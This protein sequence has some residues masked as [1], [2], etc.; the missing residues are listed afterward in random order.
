MKA[1][2]I[3]IALV[4]V[5]GHASAATW[6]V[7][8]SGGGD[9]L[10]IQEA[11][12]FASDGDL[13]LVR[14]G[15]YAQAINYRGKQLAVESTNGPAQ[16][17]IDGLRGT[18]VRVVSGEPTGTVLRGFTVTNGEIGVSVTD[19]HLGLFENIIIANAEAG[20]CLNRSQ[21]VIED[22][23][24]E[25][26]GLIYLT[27]GGLDAIDSD[28]TSRANLFERN[29]ALWGGGIYLERST[30]ISEADV[31]L[32]NV[33]FPVDEF[34]AGGGAIAG[35]SSTLTLSRSQFSHNS[36]DG[37]FVSIGGGVYLSDA[38]SQFIDCIFDRNQAGLGGG[39]HAARSVVSIDKCRF[40]GNLAIGGGGIEFSEIE[41]TTI[42]NSVFANN[43]AVSQGVPGWGGAM[44]FFVS[45][46][47]DMFVANCTLV[48][49]FGEGAAV[50]N[51]SSSQVKVSN[52]ICRNDT[53]MSEFS[54]NVSVTYSN[55]RGGY[56]GTANFDAD[57]LFL[58][59]GDDFHLQFGSP[60]IGAGTLTAPGVPTDDFDGQ[61][62]DANNAI[63]VGADEFGPALYH[64]LD[65]DLLTVRMLDEPST[66]VLLGLSF[67]TLDPPVP[68]PFGDWFLA[69][70]LW[71]LSV[72]STNPQGVLELS[73]NVTGIDA[74][75]FLQ[76]F[77]GDVLT[78]LEFVAL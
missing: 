21:V 8:Q 53:P 63:D 17:V 45:A 62:R 76:S 27:G 74:E 19:S 72:G 67:S 71:F 47:V 61:R 68:T 55:V 51:A 23:I 32:G 13:I 37:A 44:N 30:L 29:T 50:R 48:N 15:T 54:G 26:N 25:A 3:S 18:A 41:G 46:T 24:F 10:G 40:L 9:F 20:A 4:L 33:V 14:P 59:P 11:I 7:D 39:L 73:L 58:S 22:N 5:M 75:I 57:P 70:P 12:D 34:F 77:H 31:F 16:T 60:C 2:I 6:I 66:A 43:E 49:N 78:P 36:V 42:T 1:T 38:T 64:R 65:N 28:V 69:T 52:C 56:P 35:L